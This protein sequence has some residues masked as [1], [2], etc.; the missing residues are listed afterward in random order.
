MIQSAER[1]NSV[2]IFLPFSLSFFSFFLFFPL[3]FPLFLS[4]PLCFFVSSI[5]PGFSFKLVRN[6]ERSLKVM[7]SVKYNVTYAFF[8]VGWFGEI[9]A[10]PFAT[11][12]DPLSLRSC[13]STS[14]LS[15]V[16]SFRPCVRLHLLVYLLHCL[17]LCRCRRRWHHVG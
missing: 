17:D 10:H 9:L 16:D 8:E 12:I 5:I 11:L 2:L 14:Y 7:C 15:K 6:S 3:L 4:F 1:Q 13:S